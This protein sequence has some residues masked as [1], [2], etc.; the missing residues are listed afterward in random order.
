[1]SPK[2]LCDLL[3]VDAVIF[4]NYALSKPRVGGIIIPWFWGTSGLWGSTNETAVTLQL[5]DKQAQKIIWNY[6]D[7]VSGR[8]GSSPARFV[9]KKYIK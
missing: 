8:V 6:S 7:R 2:E 5:H 1:M 3:D 4:S 9:C